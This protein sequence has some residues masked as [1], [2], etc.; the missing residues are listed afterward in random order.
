MQKKTII[1][2]YECN[3]SNDFDLYTIHVTQNLPDWSDRLN[4]EI[5]ICRLKNTIESG[6]IVGDVVIVA[7]VIIV[8]V[9]ICSTALCGPWPFFFFGF[10]DNI[11]G[12]SMFFFVF[13]RV[14]S[15]S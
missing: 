1:Y 4:R 8:I 7:V 9:I 5:S 6:R 14:S 15:L 3:Y 2:P 13:V 10:R 11:P 12:R